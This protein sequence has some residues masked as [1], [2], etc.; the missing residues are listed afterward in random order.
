MWLIY[1]L[2]LIV[3]FQCSVIPLYDLCNDVCY[4]YL[5]FVLVICAHDV[6]LVYTHETTAHL[7]HV[8]LCL[9][10]KAPFM[11]MYCLK[12]TTSCKNSYRLHHP[13]AFWPVG[14]YYTLRCEYRK[15]SFHTFSLITKLLCTRL[16]IVA[17]DLLLHIE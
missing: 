5:H 6:F 14:M 10:H 1:T 15:Q 8:M 13:D 2:L 17:G 12:I 4:R 3:D 7:N 9:F 16:D 11:N